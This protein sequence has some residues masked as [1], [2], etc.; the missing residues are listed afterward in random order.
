MRFADLS[1][2]IKA[3]KGKGLES[4]LIQSFPNN[5]LT[6]EL[7]EI[8]Q[9]WGFNLVEVMHAYKGK[10]LIPKPAIKELLESRIETSLQETRSHVLSGIHTYFQEYERR[11]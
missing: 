4:K 7:Q 9:E 10:K 1:L 3:T 6:K 2:Y 8:E 11:L 5:F